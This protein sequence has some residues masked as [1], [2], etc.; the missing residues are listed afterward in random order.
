M[1]KDLI[2]PSFLLEKEEID[3]LI[4]KAQAVK[5]GS[6]EPNQP[7]ERLDSFIAACVALRAAH[8]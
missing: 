3:N 6:D 5:A 7:D 1:L 8:G 4:A 2:I